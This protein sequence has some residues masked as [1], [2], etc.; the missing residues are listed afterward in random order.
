MGM[1]KQ[2]AVFCPFSGVGEKILIGIASYFQQQENWRMRPFHLCDCYENIDFDESEFDGAIVVDILRSLPS[3]I[4]NLTLPKV[5]VFDRI[6]RTGSPLISV[7]HEEIGRLAAQHLLGRGFRNFAFVGGLNIE[8]VK[9]RY[10]AFKSHINQKNVDLHLFSESFPAGIHQLKGDECWLAF[11]DRLMT[12]LE[13]LPKPI[14]I[15]ASTDWKAF[16][17]QLACHR[18]GI[19]IPDEVALIGVNDDLPCQI[20]FPS[21]SSIRLPFERIGFRSGESVVQLVNTGQAENTRFKPIGLVTRES[22]NTFAVK[23]KVVEEALKFMQKES[24]KPIRVEEVLKHVGVS[25]SLLERRF[26]GEIGRTPLVE[27]RRQ[28]VERARGLLA[29]TELAINK[30]AEM[31][32]FSSNIRFTTVFR[33][34]VGITPTE[35]RAQ[36][37][38]Q[39]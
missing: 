13:A 21:L 9:Q 6:D 3:S 18:L 10:G 36:M 7:D 19:S 20:S 30:I 35:F 14:G 38:N 12:W 16:E 34:Q 8:Y 15:Y 27:M 25:R 26:R 22:T 5:R 1:Y 17:I 39:I 37:Q 24:I 29:D 32:G 11:R 2:V 33:E 31:C 4:E 23:D 28:R